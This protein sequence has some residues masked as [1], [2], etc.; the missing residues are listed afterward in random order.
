MHVCRLRFAS[1]PSQT[2]L[3]S[4]AGDMFAIEVDG[5]SHFIANTQAERGETLVRQLAKAGAELF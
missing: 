4:L 3:C 5:P 2:D 1:S